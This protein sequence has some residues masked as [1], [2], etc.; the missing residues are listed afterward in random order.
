MIEMFVFAVSSHYLGQIKLERSFARHFLPLVETLV[1][2][3]MM[4]LKD[5][6][7]QL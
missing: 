5:Q 4:T 2:I 7:Q 3:H 6:D 1:N